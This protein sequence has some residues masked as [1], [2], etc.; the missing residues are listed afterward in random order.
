MTGLA[1]VAAAAPV[2]AVTEE[3]KLTAIDAAAG[4]RFGRSVSVSGDT[5]VVG[6][7]FDDDA[8]SESGS[9]YVFTRS[10]TTWTQQA[11]L[12]ASDAAA[13]DQFGFSVS[14]SGDTAVVGSLLDDDA[15]SNSGSAYVF[16]RTGSTWT[17][18]AKLTATDAAAGD[19]FGFSVSVSGDTA[20]VGSLLD[21]DAGSNSGSAYVFIRSGSTWTQQAKLTATDAAAGAQFGVSVSV[22]G[23]TAVVGSWFD[24]SFSGSAYVF[25]RSGS[26]WTQQ[27]KLTATDAAA[28]DQFGV[29]V[30][31]SGDTAVVGSWYDADPRTE[32]GSAYVFSRSGST[33]TQQAKLTA[34]DAAALD[35]LGNSV[36]VSGDTVVV[37]SHQDDDAGSDSG[38][39]YVF[40]VVPPDTFVTSG[41]PGVTNSSSATFEFV[42]TDNHTPSGSLTFTCSL[43]AAPT[44]PCTSPVTYTGLADGSHTFSVAATDTSGNTDPTAATHTWTIDATGPQ[45]QFDTL[46]PAV[47]A[48]V[49]GTLVLPVR[50]QVTNTL[51]AVAFVQVTF[52]AQSPGATDATAFAFL[53]CDSTGR[54][55][56]WT[57]DPPRATG[58]YEVTA[59]GT[60][61]LGNTGDAAGPVTAVVVGAE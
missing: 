41:P 34:S 8:G 14:V 2:G 37:G 46:N 40:E 44:S 48:N 7:Y 58:I 18:Q 54:S 38:S 53:A 16:T 50:G 56:T 5:A 33:W 9:A 60:D 10:G 22:S 55:C 6:S 49:G 59:A 39:V 26:T 32:T 25:S 47:V 51:T 27:A 15:G 19:Q 30:S 31:V 21:D 13:G 61:E 35:N 52:T 57:A 1:L 29:S 12:T 36:S 20:V 17:Q 42:G 24:D 45:T 11:K 23:D 28:F 43:D 4:D 3:A